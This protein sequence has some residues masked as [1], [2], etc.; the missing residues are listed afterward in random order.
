MSHSTPIGFLNHLVEL[1]QRLLSIL[2]VWLVF[3]CIL[4]YFANNLYDFI[5]QPLLSHLPENGQMIATDVT[6]PFFIP[7]KLALMTAFFITIPYVLF[8]LW[9]FIAP[10]LYRH[11]KMKAFGFMAVGSTLYYLGMTFAYFVVCPILLKFFTQQAPHS[12][13]IATDIA[14]YLDFILKLFFAFGLAFE[15]P[16]ITTLCVLVGLLTTTQLKNNRPY[17]I[18]GTF[19]L[20]MLLT[21]PD[22]LSQL[23]LA[24]PM[25]IL[26]ECGLLCAQ[27]LERP[28]KPHTK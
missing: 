28:N 2:F 3:F 1:R 19:V 20:A 8:Q 13:V 23:L 22:V 16:V 12:V 17:I 14:S 18:I 9:R 4:I 21:P 5:A 27:F 25:C 7:F 26:F 15:I 24:G 11:E 10:G 6:T